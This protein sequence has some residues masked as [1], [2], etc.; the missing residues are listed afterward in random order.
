MKIKNIIF[1]YPS[2]KTGGAQ[3][4]FM[5]YATQLSKTEDRFNIMYVDYPDGFAKTQLQNEKITFLD[6][7]ENRISIPSDSLVIF[8]LNKV[9]LFQN[10][11]TFDK[12]KTAFMFWYLHVKN[13]HDYV[14]ARGIYLLTNKE[15]KKA[16]ECIDFLIDHDSINFLNAGSYID[17]IKDFPLSLAKNSYVV[18]KSV[19]SF[20]G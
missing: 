1:Y 11:I 9:P 17:F 12:D 14:F 6:Y 10:E 18:S 13:L 19:N 7:Y 8:Q 5:R 15:R 20:L 3:Y 4:L 2:R 16:G